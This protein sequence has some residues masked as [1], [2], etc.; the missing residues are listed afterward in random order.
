MNSK[1][2][3]DKS[4]DH[5]TPNKLIQLTLERRLR[6]LDQYMYPAPQS[7]WRVDKCLP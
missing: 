1:S 6:N 3:L 5:L 4:L 7:E 2:N